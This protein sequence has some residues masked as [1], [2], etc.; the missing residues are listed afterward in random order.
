MYQNSLRS[1]VSFLPVDKNHL[2][3]EWEIWIQRIDSTGALDCQP[4]KARSA[5][6][7]FS[8]HAGFPAVCWGGEGG[9]RLK[10]PRSHRSTGIIKLHRSGLVGKKNESQCLDQ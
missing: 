3:N 6:A 10:P 8:T 7:T 2:E 9:C 1:V 5:G 4:G